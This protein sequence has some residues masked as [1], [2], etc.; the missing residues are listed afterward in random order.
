M[1][2]VGKLPDFWRRT[3]GC[4]VHKLNRS[5]DASHLKSWKPID[6]LKALSADADIL[7][8]CTGCSKAVINTHDLELDFREKPL[9]LIDIGIPMQVSKNVLNHRMIEYRSIDDL[10][11]LPDEMK[12]D[13]LKKDLE[14]E[15][16]KEFRRFRKFCQIREMSDI[17]AGIHR[18]R[19]ELTEKII[20]HFIASNLADLDPERRKQLEEEL[21]KLIKDY[22]NSMFDFFYCAIDNFWKNNASS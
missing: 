13:F 9:L 12:N 6:C 2:S 16:E 15:I 19:V 21:K 10:L 5:V 4:K 11:Y 22:S 7:V 8:V 17:P 1:R 14:Y 20:P 3:Y 18:G